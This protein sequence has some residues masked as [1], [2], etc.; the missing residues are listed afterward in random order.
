VSILG[1]HGKLHQVLLNILSNATDAIEGEGEI[2][3]ETQST[4]T[5]V[6][7]TITDNGI[8][9]PRSHLS[10]VMD[11]FFTSKPPGEGTGLGLSISN[12]IIKEHDGTLSVDSIEGKGT[13]VTIYL[14][15]LNS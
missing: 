12:S 2:T 3:I 15:K 13:D 11:P 10:K 14:P 1:N 6:K 8:G 4:D 5:K 7:L 9:I